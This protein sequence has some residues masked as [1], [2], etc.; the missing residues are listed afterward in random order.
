MTSKYGTRAG[1]L[2]LFGELRDEVLADMRAADM[3]ADFVAGVAEL[4]NYNVPGGKLTRGLTVVHSCV[5]AARACALPAAA[6]R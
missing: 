2:E 6:A 3:P 5:R 4:L 1:F